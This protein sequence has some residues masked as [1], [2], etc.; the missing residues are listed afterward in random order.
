VIRLGLRNPKKKERKSFKTTAT[1][2]EAEKA[3]GHKYPR[4][5]RKDSKK[6]GL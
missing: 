6:F 2:E 4:N 3:I 1:A 5:F